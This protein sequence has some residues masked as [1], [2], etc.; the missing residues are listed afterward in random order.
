LPY[1]HHLKRTFSP[2][3]NHYSPEID[4]FLY[5]ISLHINLLSWSD[6]IPHPIPGIPAGPSQSG[7]HP[8]GER[9]PFQLFSVLY[10]EFDLAGTSGTVSKSCRIGK[11]ALLISSG[12]DFLTQNQTIA[13]RDFR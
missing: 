6:P 7:I 13:N 1:Q 4:H 2:K 5:T 9:L 11:P 12:N 8:F 3:K 10:G